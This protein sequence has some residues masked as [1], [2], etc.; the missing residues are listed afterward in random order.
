MGS[1]NVACGDTDPVH[2]IGPCERGIVDWTFGQD[3]SITGGQT[4]KW[5]FKVDAVHPLPVPSVHFLYLF[6]SV[7]IRVSRN[8]NYPPLILKSA[9]IS[10]LT[11][12]GTNAV[13]NP[14]VVVLSL[15]QPDRDFYRFGVGIN[16]NQIFTKLF[17]APVAPIQ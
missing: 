2:L 3:A 1:G 7:T 17:S 15:V 6:G 4:G 11:G 16:L 13:P 14:S 5:V 10:S 12:T 9:D 8:T